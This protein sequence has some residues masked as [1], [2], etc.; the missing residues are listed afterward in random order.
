MFI[1][2][3]M[4]TIGCL[5]TAFSP[6]LLLCIFTYGILAGKL[7]FQGQKTLFLLKKLHTHIIFKRMPF[8]HH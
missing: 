5:A 2:G 3:V 4:T 6:N 8:L 1:D 7:I